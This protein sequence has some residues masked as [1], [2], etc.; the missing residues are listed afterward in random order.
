MLELCSMGG[1]L[2]LI[3]SP[4]LIIILHRGIKKLSVAVSIPDSLC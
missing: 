1:K 3:D 2:S 4:H